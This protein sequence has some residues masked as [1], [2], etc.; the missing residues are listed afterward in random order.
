[1]KRFLFYIICVIVCSTSNAIGIDTY[2]D[3]KSYE[4]IID[5]CNVH[6][7]TNEDLIEESEDDYTKHLVIPII[8]A[9]IY[10]NKI[11]KIKVEYLK[12]KLYKKALLNTYLDIPPPFYE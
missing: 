11:C 7:I 10:K 2:E 5:V 3:N 6:N 12:H 1:M 4:Q 8:D 9:I